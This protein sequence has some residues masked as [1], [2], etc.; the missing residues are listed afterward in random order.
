[1]AEVGTK[2]WLTV[3]PFGLT[4]ELS[5]CVSIALMLIV[6]L[7]MINWVSGA[8]TNL[9]E[10]I[11][12]WIVL[13]L[14]GVMRMALYVASLAEC[15]GV[16]CVKYEARGL[17]RL[18]A[19][20]NERFAPSAKHKPQ[21]RQ[22]HGCHVAAQRSFIQRDRWQTLCSGLVLHRVRVMLQNVLQPRHEKDEGSVDMTREMIEV[23]GKVAEWIK[24]TQGL[25]GSRAAQTVSRRLRPQSLFE[26][27]LQR[28]RAK[29]AKLDGG[30]L[31]TSSS[32]FSDPK[33][34]LDGD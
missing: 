29:A 8:L 34:S 4:V 13:A 30:D 9:T 18:R 26:K 33:S 7:R 6:P 22:R 15:A 24:K 5:V 31:S 25:E 27:Y 28:K 16:F 3:D 10:D 1:M 17:S 20:V 23:G 21:G 19:A 11:G 14:R 32:L 2:F 12:H